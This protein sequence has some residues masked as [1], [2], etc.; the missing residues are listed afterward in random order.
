[1]R[2]RGLWIW[3]AGAGVLLVALLGMH[4]TVTHLPYVLGVGN[5]AG[6]N[7]VDWQNV[8]ARARETGFLVFYVML[9]GAGLLH[10]LIG[11]RGILLE[12]APGPGLRKVI[13]P[14]LLLAGLALFAFGTYAAFAAHAVALRAMAA[15]AQR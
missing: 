8:V 2:D 12:L 11:L 15:Q 13:G 6:S 4:M 5:P 9:L 3:Q 1:M 14:G 7:P 10:G